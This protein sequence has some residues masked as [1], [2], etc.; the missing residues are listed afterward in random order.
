MPC[1]G[2]NGRQTRNNEQAVEVKNLFFIIKIKAGCTVL[3]KQYHGTITTRAVL[4][5]EF[6]S[7]RCRGGSVALWAEQC[8]L[9]EQTK[10]QKSLWQK[11]EW[12]ESNKD[13]EFLLKPERVRLL[14]ECSCACLFLLGW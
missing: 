4:R 3:R 13:E 6:A 8:A 1:D 9:Q 12:D 11:V 14:E 10:A 7:G 2:S 5:R